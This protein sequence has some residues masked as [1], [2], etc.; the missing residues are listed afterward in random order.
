MKNKLILI[1]LFA[2]LLLTGC[3]EKTDK[4]IFYDA[5]KKIVGIETYI[6]TADITVYGNKK[7]QKYTVKQWFKAPDKCRIEIQSPESLRGKKTIY[8][9]KRAWVSH[10]KIGQEWLMEK[11]SS[12]MEKKMFLGHF[13][14]NFLNT[15]NAT[16]SR[17]IINDED[18]IVMETEIPGNHPYFNKEK[19]LF[20][21]KQYYPYRLQVFDIEDDV[22]IDVK[23]L[24]FSYN[25]SIDDKIFN[26]R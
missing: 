10:P 11:F 19:L 1:I 18:Y 26:I 17:K 24:S 12:S 22:R 6:C 7:P 15:E 23:F 21:T 13:I 4:E 16:I 2:I 5:Q 20:D 25:E 8:N 14:N 3:S 9:G